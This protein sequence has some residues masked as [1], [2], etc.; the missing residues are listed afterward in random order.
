[1]PALRST[2]LR[3]TPDAAPSGAPVIDA[4]YQIVGGKPR[5]ILRRIKT[6]LMALFWAA[7]IGFL[8]PPAWVVFQE[9]G[10]MLAAN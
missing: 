3:E 7:L 5:G 4:Q 8:I 2:V 1:M 6:A 9:V 10:A